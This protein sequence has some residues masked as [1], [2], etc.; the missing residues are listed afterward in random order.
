MKDF[1]FIVPVYNCAAYIENCVEQIHK[2][3]LESYEI[4]LINDGSK[5]DSDAVC[6]CLVEQYPA[7]VY[8]SQENQGVSAARNRGL[9][10]ACGVYVIFLDAD[11]SI[12]PE[13]MKAV[14]EV[15]QQHPE[16]D[17][18][19]Y[20][21]SF[22]YYHKG[23]CYLRSCMGYAQE[24]RMSRAAWMAALDE[25]YACNDISPVWN[26]IIRRQLLM[27]HDI[28]F[29]PKLFLYEDL[30][31]SLRLMTHCGEIYNT[32]TPIYHYRQSEDEG[33]AGRRLL[34]IPDLRQVID[35]VERALFALLG[36]DRER[37][38]GMLLRLYAVLVREKVNVSD[39]RMIREIG[40]HLKEWL[41]EHKIELG[42][43]LE[44]SQW[45]YLK[46]V[47]DHKTTQLRLRRFYIAKKHKLAVAV[48]STVLY[49]KLRK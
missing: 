12:E 4:I 40:M 30:E 23:K 20:G 42:A 9:E 14:I 13:R 6:R 32:P 25:L 28:R 2:I 17:M 21:M 35:P 31:F 36:Q 16:L 10:A 5:D 11:D 49:Q 46:L 15:I 24:G 18:A 44:K 45:D 48:K 41:Q 29:D 26:K 22:D 8:L 34:R 39:G 43:L 47:M 1:S 19:L 27:D 37:V 38:N 33:N 7:V 3:G